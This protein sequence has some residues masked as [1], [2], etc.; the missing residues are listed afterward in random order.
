MAV[1]GQDKGGNC[2]LGRGDV[3]IIHPYNTV[4]GDAALFIFPMPPHFWCAGGYVAQPI[5]ELCPA[6]KMRHPKPEIQ[7]P[8]QW[9]CRLIHQFFFSKNHYGAAD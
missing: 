6:S 2:S 7:R 5:P 3:G 1:T 9:D 8:R 4:A